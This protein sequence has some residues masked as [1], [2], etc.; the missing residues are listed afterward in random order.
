MMGARGSSKPAKTR[1]AW[2]ALGARLSEMPGLRALDMSYNTL[3]SE[4]AARRPDAV[5]ALDADRVE[6]GRVFEDGSVSTS[7]LFSGEDGTRYK[8]AYAPVFLDGEPGEVV[9]AVGVEAWGRGDSR[10]DQRAWRFVER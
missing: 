5:A 3:T 9:A 6:V 2:A 7:V 10:S 1:Q 4:K 8:Y